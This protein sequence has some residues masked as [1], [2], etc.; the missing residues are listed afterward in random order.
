MGIV[1]K[2]GDCGKTSLLSGEGVSK[3]EARVEAYGT[4]DELNSAVGLARSFIQ[5][6]EGSGLKALSREIQELQ[7]DLF[8]FASE[9]ASLDPS[10]QEWVEPTDEGHVERIDSR[11]A[12]LEK[13][14]KLPPS[15][16]IPGACKES[17]TLD[18]ART[19]ARRLERRV[20]G[21]CA[22]GEYANGAGLKYANRI[23]D[24]LFLLARAVEKEIGITYDL[25]GD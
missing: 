22:S 9:L 19:V 25:K 8:R 20:V 21:L 4:I 1:T 13:S 18:V 15:F 3:A 14:V 7:L 11:I 17:A 10:S 5:E 12:E 6:R 24:Y 23:S 16:I 2:R